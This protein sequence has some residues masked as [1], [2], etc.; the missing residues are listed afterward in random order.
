MSL[1]DWRE[2]PIGK[3][4][5]RDAFDCGNT[6]LNEYL[7]RYARKNHERGGAK[8]ILALDKAN[9]AILG[10]YSLSPASV[11]YARVP[12]IAKHNL[13]RYEVPG[14]RLAR[15]AVAITMQN[16][17]LGG[18]LLLSA[19]RR[20]ILASLEI[21]GTILLIDAKDERVTSWYASFGAIPMLDA[22]LSLVL[23]LAT[24]LPLVQ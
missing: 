19:A 9:N 10:Y 7:R 17:G 12:E 2:A 11:E 16:Q 21:G 5:D 8:T 3:D 15:L 22:P 20:C 4:Y 18:Q 23:P 24:V 13:G 6:P 1:P 14:F